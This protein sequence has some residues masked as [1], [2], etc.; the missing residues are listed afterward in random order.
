MSDPSKLYS[1]LNPNKEVIMWAVMDERD[2]HIVSESSSYYECLR[3]M[4]EHNDGYYIIRAT[5]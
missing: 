2:G 3:Y 1:W 4:A 5:L